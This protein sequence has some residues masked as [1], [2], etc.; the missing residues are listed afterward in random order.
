MDSRTLIDPAKK[1]LLE[2]TSGKRWCS[3]VGIEKRDSDFGLV[4]S[5]RP[6]TKATAERFVKGLDL[7]V[8]VRVR[9]LGP[10]RAR[11]APSAAGEP[12]VSEETLSR[13][14]ASAT[15]RQNS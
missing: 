6:G 9:E 14:R 13:L 10:V 5:V 12:K 11:E 7:G 2:K 15:R 4:L 3:G 1:T 8:P